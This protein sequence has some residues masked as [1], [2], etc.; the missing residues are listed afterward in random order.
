[1]YWVIHITF[2][3]LANYKTK[4][5]SLQPSAYQK[6]D[7]SVKIEFSV[8]EFPFGGEPHSLLTQTGDLKGRYYFTSASD[9]PHRLCFKAKRLEGNDTGPIT[10]IATGIE[11]LFGNSGNP[12]VVS[13]TEA[14]LGKLEEYVSYLIEQAGI[15]K[16]EQDRLSYKEQEFQALSENVN[17]SSKLVCLIQIGII[18]VVNVFGFVNMRNYFKTKKIT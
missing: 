11:F 9:G 4:V 10:P 12:D 6:L 1:M 16:H 17:K 8:T 3:I 18:L 15:L 13:H 2:L 14:N 7:P 5:F